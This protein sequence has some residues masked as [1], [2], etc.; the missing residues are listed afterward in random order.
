MRDGHREIPINQALCR[1]DHLWGVERK[2]VLLTLMFVV[3]FVVLAFDL[4]LSI[5]AFIMWILV[6][7][8]LRIMAKA[9]PIMSV[10]YLRHIRYLPHYRA[11]STPFVMTNKH[12][13]GWQK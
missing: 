12:Y 5:F 7:Q 8:A 13:K 4:S 3:M 6:Y 9:D 2:L 10:V 11:H 1:P